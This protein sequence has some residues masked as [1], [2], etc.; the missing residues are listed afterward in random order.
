MVK[1]LMFLLAILLVMIA[2]I[3]KLVKII[4]NASMGVAISILSRKDPIFI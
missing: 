3:C 4:I 2:D 1:N